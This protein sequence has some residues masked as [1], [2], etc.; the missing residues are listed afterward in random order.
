[1]S[2]IT[3][4]EIR[5][6]VARAARTVS[7]TWPL[8]SFIAVNPLAGHEHRP[9]GELTAALGESPT[10]PET[11]Y[12]AEYRDGRIPDAAVREALHDVLPEVAA[13]D[14]LAAAGRT[15]SGVDIAL[16]ALQNPPSGSDNETAADD[17]GADVDQYLSALLGR[18]YADPV[19]APPA[20]GTLYARFREVVRHDHSLP[21]ASR[22]VLAD[23]PAAPEEAIA[24][25]LRSTHPTAEG[26]ETVVTAQLRALPGWVSHLAWRASRTGD[27]TLTDYVAMR[28][29]LLRALNRDEPPPADTL[30]PPL[31]VDPEWVARVSELC[32]GGPEG[33]AHVLHVLAFLDAPTRRMVW[34]TATECAY[35]A[36]LFRSLDDA[37]GEPAAP[38]EAQLMFC[39]DVRS[40]GFRRHLERDPGIRTLGFA[41]FFGIPLQHTPLLGQAP[42]EQYP[43]LL[44][45]GLPSGEEP[46]DP[47]ALDAAWRRAAAD[48]AADRA[49]KR[50]A[51]TP[52][53]A[54]TWAEASGWGGLLSGMVRPLTRR[55]RHRTEVETVID[56]CRRLPLDQRAGIAESVLRMTGLTEFAPLVVLAGHASSTVNN[57]YRA[58]LDCGAC[59]GNAGAAN[60]RAA[61]AI[62]NDP[63]VRQRLGERGL[64]I[65]ETTWF[66]AAEH[67]T[68]T[69]AL[70]LLDR[71][72]I[73]QAHR[74]AV[75][76]LETIA[77]EA[78]DRLT[79]ER[80]TVLPGAVAR[81]SLA[82]VRKRA[83]DWA[84]MYPELGLAG[85]AALIIAPRAITRGADLERRVFLHD[86]DPA[87]DPDSTGLANIMTAPLIVAQWINA[88][89]YFSTIQPQRYGAGDKTLHNPV[90]DLGVLAGHTGDL[91]TG[92]P[93]QSVAAGT[94]LLH[95][96]LRL[97][98]LIQAPLDRIGRIVSATDALRDLLDGDWITLH[99][100]GG[101][102]DPWLRYTRYGFTPAR[103][104]DARLTRDERTSA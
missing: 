1:M 49:R 35:R 79:R 14:A 54:F 27:A 83:E 82:T 43:A 85:N 36:E 102:D 70:R 84:E 11:A 53:S 96:P 87:S 61:A 68:T 97:S 73:P 80:A 71:H 50:V 39:I 30:V 7:P 2:L 66:V 92:L 15:A 63:E 34:Q 40:E 57:L 76:R 69:D 90:G 6:H 42:R 17:L 55:F 33:R 98:V 103:P 86:Y 93:W 91:R 67:D 94:E 24:A 78:G 75:A 46:V 8:T 89:Y 104:T 4:P 56:V 32:F 37:T 29:S 19:W 23:L 101:A 62:F 64:V 95:T 38:A 44:S 74:D 16:C 3:A 60:A 100:R 31:G 10:R 77:A 88:Q 52:V 47:S 5:A 81:T 26:I 51:G 65:P 58:A 28:L 48:G 59:G 12:L 9:I 18:L 13:I 41:G 72:L 25:V 22:R 99:A 45:A 21:R 20:S